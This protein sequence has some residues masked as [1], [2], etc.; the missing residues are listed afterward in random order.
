MLLGFIGGFSKE[1]SL[2]SGFNQLFGF[3][4]ETVIKEAYKPPFFKGVMGALQ[5]E[6]FKSF[7][8]LNKMFIFPLGKCLDLPH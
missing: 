1:F 7:P 8:G 2:T 4:G 3:G 6:V 5:L